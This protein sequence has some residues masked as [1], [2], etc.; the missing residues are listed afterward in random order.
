M[1][2]IL[3]SYEHGLE[4]LLQ[5]FGREHPRYVEAMTL[6]SRLHENITAT[7]RY[8]DTNSGDQNVPR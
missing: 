5:A 1:T 3:A 2:D 4:R 6:Q 7:R 8:G